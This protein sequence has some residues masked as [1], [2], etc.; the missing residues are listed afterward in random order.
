MFTN[1]DA[2]WMMSND[3]GTWINVGLRGGMLL[4]NTCLLLCVMRVIIEKLRRH[5]NNANHIK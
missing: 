1:N 3:Y 2:C 4:F 5:I